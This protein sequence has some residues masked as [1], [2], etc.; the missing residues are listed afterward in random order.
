MICCDITFGSLIFNLLV[1]TC[2]NILYRNCLLCIYVLI[3]DGPR[4]PKHIVEIF[5]KKSM[6]EYLKLVGIKTL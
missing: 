6:H 4:R 5:M 1:H 2:D 3:E